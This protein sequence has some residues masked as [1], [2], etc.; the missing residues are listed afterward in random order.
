MKLIVISDSPRRF[1]FSLKNRLGAELVK[2]E[3][4]VIDVQE[5]ISILQDSLVILRAYSIYRLVSAASLVK[6]ARPRMVINNP[7]LVMRCACR[8]MLYQYLQ[9]LGLPV[10]RRYHIYDVCN[11]SDIVDKVRGRTYILTYAKSD[12]DGIVESPQALVSVVEHRFYMSAEDTKVNIFVPDVE[13]VQDILIVGNEPLTEIK[14]EYEDVVSKFVEKVGQG[15]YLLKLAKQ[16]GRTVIVDVDPVPEIYEEE[17]IEK[18]IKF[19]K[20]MLE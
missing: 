11:V 7:D 18:A 14:K 1:E 13:D 10:P 12:I 17:H 4:S 6:I 20:M 2:L 3:N 5:L 15:I 19:I 9:E 8:E 16:R